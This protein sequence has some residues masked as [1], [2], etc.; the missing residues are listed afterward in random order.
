MN[1][2]RHVMPEFSSGAMADIAF[3]M[4]IFYMVAT[5]IKEQKGLALLLPN[6]ELNQIT[7]PKNDRNLFRININSSNQLMVEG[8]TLY[9]LSGIR[10][11]IKKFVLN[12]KKDPDLSDN[13]LDAVVS[14]KADRGSTYK[15]FIEALD[16][17]QAAYYEIYAA[18]IGISP[19]QFRKLKTKNFK[20]R[21]VYE[22]AR[23]GIPMNISI[24]ESR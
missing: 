6:Y 1:H 10:K 12:Y 24:A 19:E 13:P 4:L 20:E 7:I 2:T 15:I 3:L 21:A 23:Q 18:R 5:E 9:T 11:D 16:E 22:K 14:I 8:K 17:A